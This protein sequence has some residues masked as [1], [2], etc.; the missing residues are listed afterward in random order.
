MVVSDDKAAVAVGGGARLGEVYVRVAEQTGNASTVVAGTCP[1][2]GVGGHVL[3]ALGGGSARGRQR[4][5]WSLCAQPPP[6]A[7][8]CPAPTRAPPPRAGGGMGWLSM[9]HGMAC[10]QLEELTMVDADGKVVVASRDQ[11]RELFA[12]SCG[13][14]GGNF[15]AVRGPAAAGAPW[16]SARLAPAGAHCPLHTHTLFHCRGCRWR[17]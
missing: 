10:D 2:V 15:G 6:T 12:A 4:G 5:Q 7:C 14:G 8:A 3:G 9:L 13:G 16:G 1:S 17:R 11:N